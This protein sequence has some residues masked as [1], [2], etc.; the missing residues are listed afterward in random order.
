MGM[1]TQT[2]LIPRPNTDVAVQETEPLNIGAMVQR[3]LDG[4]HASENATA[5]EKL[6]DVHIKLEDRNA[7]KIFNTDF[8]GLQ[9]ELPKVKALKPVNCKDGSLKYMF[10]PFED[11]DDQVR[12]ICLRFGFTYSFEADPASKAGYVTCI[13]T[14]SHRGG[15]SRRIPFS[16]RIG[17]GPPGCT[18]SQSD[19]SAYSQAKRGALCYALNIR[20]DKAMEHDPRQESHPIT[21]DQAFELERRVKETNSN[22]EAF[23]KFA[24]ADLTAKDRWATIP[25][26]RYP[27]LDAMLRRKEAKR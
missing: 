17:S 9:G 21:A 13:C 12:P 15:H 7:A 20:I 23:L 8:I 5:I 19:M 22:V 10:A 14:L 16:I 24:G 3:I 26:N 4:G 18:E 1:N 2:E 11:I 25:A 27:E 6:L